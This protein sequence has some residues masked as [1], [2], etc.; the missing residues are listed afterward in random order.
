MG[1]GKPKVHQTY[2]FPWIVSSVNSDSALDLSERLTTYPHC[3]LEIM[4]EEAKRKNYVE[5]LE[6]D[7][8]FIARDEFPN[9]VNFYIDNMGNLIVYTD[10][11]TFNNFSIDGNG[12]LK[13]SG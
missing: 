4:T 7:L 8:S 6:G 1:K 12:D 5:H 2:T 13:Y 10:D 11:D 9:G 3:Y